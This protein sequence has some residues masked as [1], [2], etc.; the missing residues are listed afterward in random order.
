MEEEFALL[1]KRLDADEDQ[2]EAVLTWYL[3][4]FK[5]YSGLRS[6]NFRTKR[7]WHAVIVM[8]IMNYTTLTSMKEIP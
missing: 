7:R 3:S 1:L 2:T 4:R 8:M 6:R 5:E